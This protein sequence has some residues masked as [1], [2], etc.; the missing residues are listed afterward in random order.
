M[1]EAD[2]LDIIEKRHGHRT[3]AE[4]QQVND[5][6]DARSDDADQDT[7]TEIACFNSHKVYDTEHGNEQHGHHGQDRVE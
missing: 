6:A 4:H 7:F 5:N 1:P 2:V 3:P